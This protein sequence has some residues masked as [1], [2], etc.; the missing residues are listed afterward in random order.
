MVKRHRARAIGKKL[1][2]VTPYRNLAVDVRKTYENKGVLA[3][4][5]AETDKSGQVMYLVYVFEKGY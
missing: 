2:Y 5:V 4:I 3:E 1:V